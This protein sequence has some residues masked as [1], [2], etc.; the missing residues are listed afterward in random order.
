MPKKEKNA[1]EE[2]WDKIDEFLSQKLVTSDDLLEAALRD[3]EKANL[4]GIQVTPNQGKLLQLL[5]QIQGARR[6][7]EMGT[8]G[9]YS[10]ICLARALPPGGCLISLELDPAY[11]QV[12]RKNIERA[13]LHRRVTIK[14]GPANDSLA[15]LVS[16][17]VAPFDFIFID[18]DKA[19]YPDYLRFAMKLS[20]PGTVIV[21]DNVVRKGAVIEANSSDANVQGVRRMLDMIAS[22][23]RVSATGIQTVG[24]KGHDGFVLARVN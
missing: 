3:S 9:G 11:A 24:S 20:R 23:N 4:P 2:L 5:A 22:E 16:E 17:K 13:G 14:V 18:A 19:G 10:T 21:A 1:S 7:L 12:A 15:Q 6:I 8:L